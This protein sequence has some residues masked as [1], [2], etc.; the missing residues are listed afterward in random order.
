MFKVTKDHSWEFSEGTKGVIR[1]RKSKDRKYNGQKKKDKH[2]LF[3]RICLVL[4]G[5][6]FAKHESFI[7]VSP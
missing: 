1:S 3:I 4:S 5:V 6:V 2:L 7:Y